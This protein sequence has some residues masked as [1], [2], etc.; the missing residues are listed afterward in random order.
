MDATDSPEGRQGNREKYRRKGDLHFALVAE[1]EVATE[2]AQRRNPDLKALWGDI[3]A[4][5][6]EGADAATSAWIAGQCNR[7]LGQALAQEEEKLH[8]GSREYGQ[9]GGAAGFSEFKVLQPL[10]RGAPTKS[11]VGTRWV[12]IWKLRRLVWLRKTTRVR[13]RR[14]AA[15]APQAV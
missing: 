8:G 11:I 10:E 6:V 14:E 13:A 3:H 5:G 1:K 2:H 4:S 15:W 12:V 7:V 9:G